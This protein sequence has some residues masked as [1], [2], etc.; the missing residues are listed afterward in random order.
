MKNQ[1]LVLVIF[2]GACSVRVL[3]AKTVDL[4]IMH[5]DVL[6]GYH[7]FGGARVGELH[8]QRIRRCTP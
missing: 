3:V 1:R 6:G 8:A 2:G 7:R 5:E 4:Q